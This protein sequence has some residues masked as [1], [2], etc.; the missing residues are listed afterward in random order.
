MPRLSAIHAA[1]IAVVAAITT[2]LENKEPEVRLAAAN[3]LGELSWKAQPAVPSLVQTLHDEAAARTLG[4]IGPPA[5]SAIPELTRLTQAKEE[6]VRAAAKGA[7][8]K[9]EPPA[10]PGKE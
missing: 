10:P 7:L 4:K 1:D 6:S 2:A 3:P 9:I 8:E 5:R